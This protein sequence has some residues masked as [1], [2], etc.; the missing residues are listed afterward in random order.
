MN[1]VVNESEG[2]ILTQIN[3]SL[4]LRDEKKLV[5]STKLNKVSGAIVAYDNYPHPNLFTIVPNVNKF[6]FKTSQHN[7]DTVLNRIKYFVGNNIPMVFIGPYAYVAAAIAG[8]RVLTGI[9]RGKEYHRKINSHLGQ[10]RAKTH[11]PFV[12][13]LSDVPDNEHFLLAWDFNARDS[14]GN[15]GNTRKFIPKKKRYMQQISYLQLS[16]LEHEF[17]FPQIV[18]FPSFKFLCIPES[19]DTCEIISDKSIVATMI[20][21][22]LNNQIRAP[23]EQQSQSTKKEQTITTAA[24]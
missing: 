6:D 16:D 11:S 20:Y 10:Y 17:A 5:N 19:L 7:D 13:D 12:I 2:K 15:F 1:V 14:S 4:G 3:N 21:K 8:A 9:L 24:H 18:Y 23:W 22:F